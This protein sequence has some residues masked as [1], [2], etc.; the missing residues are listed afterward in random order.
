MF[1]CEVVLYRNT[2]SVSILGEVMNC[3]SLHVAD[4]IL[5]FAYTAALVAEMITF[6]LKENRRAVASFIGSK[7]NDRRIKEYKKLLCEKV[8]CGTQ[9]LRT[10]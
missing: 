1:V 5:R 2:S 3:L 8:P 7:W 6:G 4:L 10:P 9:Y